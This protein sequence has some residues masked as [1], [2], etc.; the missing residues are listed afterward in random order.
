MLC[1]WYSLDSE[2][3][4]VDEVSDPSIVNQDL[5]PKKRSLYRLSQ[6]AECPAEL[7][8]TQ[9]STF[10]HWWPEFAGRRAQS[11]SRCS[12]TFGTADDW[13]R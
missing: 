3:E 5:S 10:L 11:P 1:S 7:R 8:W 12:S 6:I 13:H 4:N 9:N 2:E